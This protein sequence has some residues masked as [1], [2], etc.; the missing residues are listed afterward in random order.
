MSAS[1][2]VKVTVSVP[3]LGLSDEYR[4]F[5]FRRSYFLSEDSASLLLFT[6]HLE[7][8]SSSDFLVSL[9]SVLS[10]SSLRLE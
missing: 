1:L 6:L 10:P 9:I 3:L 8:V 7:S 5:L 4:H 2:S